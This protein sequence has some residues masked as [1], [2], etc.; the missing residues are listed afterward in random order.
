[1]EETPLNGSTIR[2]GVLSWIKSI[3]L[4]AFKTSKMNKKSAPA[5]SKDAYQSLDPEKIR[6]MYR[7]ISEA[8]SEI[9]SATYEQLATHMNEKPERIW[10]RL[11]EGQVIGLWH[12]TAERRVMSSGRSGFVWKAGKGEDEAVKKKKVM[13]G[14]DVS[15]F[16]KAILNQPAPSQATQRLLF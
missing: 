2:V 5:T 10:K 4:N 16:S 9:G 15:S 3:A 1:M 11:S 12:R 13:K 6:L 7:K 8:L 14:P